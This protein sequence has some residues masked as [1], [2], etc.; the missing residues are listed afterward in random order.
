MP[1]LVLEQCRASR[2]WD[3]KYEELHV[4]Q[5][6]QVLPSNTIST[7]RRRHAW[8]Q[9]PDKHREP[10][11]PGN[12]HRQGTHLNETLNG[13][14]LFR[15]DIVVVSEEQ[16]C[17]DAGQREQIHQRLCADSFASRHLSTLKVSCHPFL[18]CFKGQVYQ[19]LHA[20]ICVGNKLGWTKTPAEPRLTRKPP[21]E[22][23]T[24][25]I[26]TVNGP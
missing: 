1:Q 10:I 18:T 20:G 19:S 12:M 9:Q 23:T 2:Q 26:L 3:P 16:V 22:P 14:G 5:S 8:Q 4:E 25:F 7:H 13:F 21:E 6:H 17:L 15:G 24:P 11:E